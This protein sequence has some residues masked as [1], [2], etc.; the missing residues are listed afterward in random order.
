[1]A[2]ARTDSDAGLGARIATP[3][4]FNEIHRSLWESARC[5]DDVAAEHGLD[6]DSSPAR[7]LRHLIAR[8]FDLESPDSV[9][10]AQR[11]PGVR[12]RSSRR[13]PAPP[14]SCCALC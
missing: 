6:R 10:G 1:V 14:T 13:R 12:R 2:A 7:L 8:R 3:R 5:P 11:G 9:A 4:A